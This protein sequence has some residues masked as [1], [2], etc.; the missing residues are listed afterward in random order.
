MHNNVVEKYRV[1]EREREVYRMSYV[2][3]IVCMQLIKSGMA[4]L[5]PA[6]LAL[7]MPAACPRLIRHIKGA[8]VPQG[9]GQ[10]KIWICRRPRRPSFVSI[11]P[12]SHQNSP[13]NNGQMSSL[14]GRNL[15]RLCR[16]I[17]FLFFSFSLTM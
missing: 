14:W 17:L 6:E 9:A 4:I 12:P 15:A 13:N 11:M 16:L 1:R 5:S 3:S 2:V 8:G 10:S 7:M